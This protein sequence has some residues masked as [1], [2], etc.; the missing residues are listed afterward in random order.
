[1]LERKALLVGSLPF[2]NEEE[3]MRQAINI[4][5]NTLFSLPDGEVGEKS[6][7]YPLGS[8][9]GWAMA[10]IDS[11]IADQERWE[12]VKDGQYGE[13]GFPIDYDSLYKV[14]PKVSP[15]EMVQHLNFHYHDYFRTSYPLFQQLR[16]QHQFPKLQFQVGTP[17]GMAIALHMLEPN[18][19]FRYYD[20][21]NERL[22]YEMNEILKQA[23]DDV[24]IQLEC[25]AELGLLYQSP[26]MIDHALNSVIG[27]VKR[28]EYPASIGIHLCYGDLNNKS[29]IHPPTLEILA[30]FTNQLIQ[31]WP[32]THS[33][34]Y[35]HFPLAEGE[36]PPKKEE[37]FYQP[38]KEIHLP[39]E[40][41]FIA[42]IVHEKCSFD[43]LKEI[44]NTIESIR[45][46]KV[47]LACS[48]GMGRRSPEVSQHLMRVMKR[49][50]EEK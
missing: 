44:R 42:G 10:A 48:C 47:D 7:Q 46:H 3:A 4:L 45:D 32:Q 12:I 17:T 43:D 31:N 5:G 22:A 34:R 2:E 28:F 37:N 49:L 8:R 50:T 6:E 23:D 19:I 18:Q 30:S 9:Q 26:E 11:C 35:V 40:T 13:N 20:S 15:Q 41:R 16:E 25:P 21:F 1:M 33:L 36:I 24:V 14:K 29:L 38:L 27:L 39:S